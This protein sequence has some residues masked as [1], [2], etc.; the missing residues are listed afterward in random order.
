M[1][2]YRDQNRIALAERA[3]GQASAVPIITQHPLQ[4]TV[5]YGGGMNFEQ[6]LSADLRVFGRFGWNEGQHE[7]YAYTEVDQTFQL[8]GDPRRQPLASCQRQGR[9]RRH[10]QRHQA[11]PPAI[12]NARRPGLPAGRWRSQLRA[13][14][15]SRELLQR[16][17]LARASSQPSTSSSSRI[18]GYNQARGPVA[19]FTV[20]SHIDF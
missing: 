15:H 20:R 17:Q 7:S 16:A 14:R 11:R 5:K 4:T 18:P 2:D 9:T 1:G 8:G 6:E 10:L 13:R 12:P 3:L 19:V